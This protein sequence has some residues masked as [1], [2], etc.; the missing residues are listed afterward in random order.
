LKVATMNEWEDTP[1]FDKF[2]SSFWSSSSCGL[3]ETSR[4]VD[5][6]TQILKI[7]R[8]WEK[9]GKMYVSPSPAAHHHHHR[10]REKNFFFREIFNNNIYFSYWSMPPQWNFWELISFVV[11]GGAGAAV[12]WRPSSMMVDYREREE[13]L[14]EKKV[15]VCMFPH[16]IT[17]GWRPT[18]ERS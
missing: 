5:Y 4:V 14:R 12:Y 16:Y 3:R 9:K 7:W 17:A 18:T 11:F 15:F 1:F 8:F 10:E 6:Y 13:R 2:C